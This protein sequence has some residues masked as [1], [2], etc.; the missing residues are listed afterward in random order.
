MGD[1]DCPIKFL[2]TCQGKR[3]RST[4]FKA[5]NDFRAHY[6]TDKLKSCR[7]LLSRSV[8]ETI[9][10]LPDLGD[11]HGLIIRHQSIIVSEPNPPY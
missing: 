1:W 3:D 8:M 5:K 2:S 7:S 9:Y 10:D 4:P 11:I 6:Q